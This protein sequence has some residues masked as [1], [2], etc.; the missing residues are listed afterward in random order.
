MIGWNDTLKGGWLRYVFSHKNAQTSVLARG[1][2]MP[3]LNHVELMPF[4]KYVESFLKGALYKE[5]TVKINGTFRDMIT[6]EIV[7]GDIF[8]AHVVGDSIEETYRAYLSWWN[9]V[10]YAHDH[11]REFVSVKVAETETMVI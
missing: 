3:E 2:D 8:N 6:G 10:R 7:K 9:H 1:V 11:P 5:K 4:R